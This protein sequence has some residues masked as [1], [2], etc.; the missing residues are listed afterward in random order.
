MTLKIA[1]TLALLL[2]ETA[3]ST[4]QFIESCLF[5]AMILFLAPANDAQWKVGGDVAAKGWP[6]AHNPMTSLT[7]GTPRK[8]YIAPYQFHVLA[9]G[10]KDFGRAPTVENRAPSTIFR[11][12]FTGL[13]S[14]HRESRAT[15]PPRVPCD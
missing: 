13:P 5:P 1:A 12:S 4:K 15:L 8:G 9:G 3:R 11:Q 14:F 2:N 7:R 6:F 10:T